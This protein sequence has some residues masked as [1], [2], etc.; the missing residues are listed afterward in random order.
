MLGLLLALV[1]CKGEQ[2][3]AAEQS[4]AGQATP[5]P[6]TADTTAPSTAGSDST[7]AGTENRSGRPS[8]DMPPDSAT[9]GPALTEQD[10]AVAWTTEPVTQR[11]TPPPVATLSEVR[12]GTHAGYDRVVFQFAD[13]L[14]P[15]YE[16]EYPDGP[17]Y[18]CGSGDDVSVEGAARLVVKLLAARAHDDQGQVTIAERQRVP[19][20]P[21][22]IEL[23]L[24][25]DFEAQVEWV[26][27]LSARR[28]YRVME[29]SGP[30]RLVLDVQH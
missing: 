26:V 27:G 11:R 6:G 16:I 20:L 22:L 2:T 13:A 28:P 12:T 18:Q 3:P 30:P 24:T 7:Q 25:C 21:V 19:A 17:L 10:T 4:T 5:T 23:K 14:L 15:G 8:Q 9:G 29:L 1:A